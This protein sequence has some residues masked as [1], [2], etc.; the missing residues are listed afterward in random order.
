MYFKAERIRNWTIHLEFKR[1]MLNLFAGK[2]HINYANNARLYLQ[3]MLNLHID[4]SWLLKQ[5]CNGF[6]SIRRSDQFWAGLWSDLVIEQLMMRSKKNRGGF[7]RGRG[8]TE[9]TWFMGWLHAKMWGSSLC[10]GISNKTA[11]IQWICGDEYNTL[12]KKQFLCQ[13]SQKFDPFLDDSRL[14]CI[15]T[16]VAAGD[17]AINCDEVETIGA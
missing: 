5:F 15:S 9:Y 7:T 1:K 16:G 8:M 4:H 10:N 3:I 6:H 2:G 12:W 14:H 11:S 17:D 13:A